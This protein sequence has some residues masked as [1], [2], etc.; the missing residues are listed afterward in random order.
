MSMALNP[1]GIKVYI[2]GVFAAGAKNLSLT[3]TRRIHKVRSCLQND[4]AGTVEFGR[5]CVVCLDEVIL[6]DGGSVFADEC[7]VK[8]IAGNKIIICSSCVW[9]RRAWT[10]K[11]GMAVEAWEFMCEGWEET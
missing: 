4:S 6:S 10:V 8:L 5:E 7:Q 3:R 11:D 2:D 1:K 9:T